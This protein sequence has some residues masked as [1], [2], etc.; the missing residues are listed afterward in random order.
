MWRALRDEKWEVFG[1]GST[2]RS[3]RGDQSSVELRPMSLLWAN[4]MILSP[5]FNSF[6]KGKLIGSVLLT[7]INL[8]LI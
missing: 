2:L 1:L 6:R 4:K 3:G 5:G 7:F 8:R